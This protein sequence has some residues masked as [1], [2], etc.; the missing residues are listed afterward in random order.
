MPVMQKKQR[1]G[2]SLSDARL[3]FRVHVA[4]AQSRSYKACPL[5]TEIRLNMPP[6][7]QYLFA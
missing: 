6:I 2:A 7:G 5:M 1:V 4:G 3:P